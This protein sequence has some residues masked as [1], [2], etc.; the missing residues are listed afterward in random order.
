MTVVMYLGSL[1]QFCCREGG[2][3]QTNTTGVCGECS[4][5]M[6][7]TGFAPAPGGVCFPSAQAPGRFARDLSK[8]GPGFY[9]L[10]R[11]K[12]LRF[13]FWVLH[14][15]RDSVGHAFCALPGPSNSGD[16]VLGECTVPCALCILI[17]SPVPAAWFPGCAA[18]APSQV[19][20]VSPLGSL[21]LPMT[22]LGDVNCPWSQ[23][24]LVS[25]CKPA[26]SLVEDDVSRAEIAPSPSPSSSGCTHLPLCLWQGEGPVCR[27]LALNWYSLNPLFC[28]QSRL[29]LRLEF[30]VGKFSLFHFVLSLSGCP[31]VGVAISC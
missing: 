6:D 17:T 25:S 16:Q 30:F 21:S 15:G 24:D 2:T 13:R 11:S 10:P 20:P 3:L 8:S 14:K 9:T 19:C 27:W 26:H 18:R 31:T 28:E 22:L 7:H 29:C 23:E 1:V 5:Y 4:Q 12:L